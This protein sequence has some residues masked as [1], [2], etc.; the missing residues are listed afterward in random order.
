MEVALISLAILLGLTLLVLVPIL[1]VLLVLTKRKNRLLQERIA[2]LQLA[3]GNRS[4][5]Q[6]NS[7]PCRLKKK[8]SNVGTRSASESGVYDMSESSACG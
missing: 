1:V 3:N 5:K 6:L 8:G 4:V 2:D 7:L